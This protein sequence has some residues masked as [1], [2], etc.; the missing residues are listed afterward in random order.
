MAIHDTILPAG[1][2]CPECGYEVGASPRW[3][4]SECGRIV[5]VADLDHHAARAG[6]GARATRLARVQA[7]VVTSAACVIGAMVWMLS[8]DS[9]PAMGSMIVVAGLPMVSMGGEWAVGATAPRPERGA[10]RLAWMRNSPYLH[11]AWASVPLFVAGI[12]G[13]G[14]LA[15]AMGASDGVRAACLV[16]CIATLFGVWVVV[17]LMSGERFRRSWVTHSVQMGLIRAGPTAGYQALL[18]IV[19]LLSI[20]WAAAMVGCCL[21]A[22]DLAGW[23]L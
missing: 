12:V 16:V 17:G 19:T 21:A 10:W 11:I 8:G 23:R 20:L 1:F 4:C 15:K 14:L 3:V 5:V 2:V 18:T 22:I 7:A 9:G 13:C 6:A